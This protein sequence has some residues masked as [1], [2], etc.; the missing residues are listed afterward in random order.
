VSSE[1]CTKFMSLCQRRPDI[2]PQNARPAVS[3]HW[4]GFDDGNVRASSS[5]D[6][7]IDEP[8]VDLGGSSEKCNVGGSDSQVQRL[9]K[10]QGSVHTAPEP[11]T[12][13]QFK[14]TMQ[15]AVDK[16]ETETDV[17]PAPATGGLV[18]R[19][20]VKDRINMF[21][22]QK[23][24]QTPSSGN[25]NSAVANKAVPGKGE[26]RRVP[27]G[28]SMEKLVRRWSNVSDMSID[29]SNNDSSSLNEKKEDGTFIGTPTST[30]LEGNS[31][32]RADKDSSRLTDSVTSQPW[33]C[34]RDGMSMGSTSI[35]NCS[36]SVSNDVPSSYK[37]TKSCAEDDMVVNTSF[38]S[39]SSFGKE[40]VSGH[41]A[42]NFSTRNR[43]KTSPKP[44]EEAS[45]KHKDI[46][47]SSSPEEHVHMIDKEITAVVHEVPDSSEQ[48]GPNDTR[49][50]RLHTKD[51]HTE[52]DMMEKKAR[53]TRT[54]EKISGGVKPKSKALP[55]SR[56]NLRGSSGREEISSIETEGRDV[57]MQRN[58]VPIKADNM[59]RKVISGSDSDCSG[60][61]GSNL[62]RQSSNAE[63]ELNSQAKVRPA[64]G[65]QDRH[66]E[67][68]MKANELEKLYA[69]HKLTS[70]RRGKSTDAQ[71]D[72]TP[73][74]SEVKPVQ[75][76]PEKIYTKQ[77]VKESITTND[78]DA[79]ELLK[80]V[81]NQ[82]YSSIPQKF[83]ILSLE[84][85]RGKF[86]DQYMQKRDAKLKEDWKLQRQE[87]EAMLKA[88]HESLERSKAELQAKFA[89]SVDCSD[90]SY[91]SR[92]Q[93]TPPLQSTR[94]KKDQVLI[95][96]EISSLM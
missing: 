51:I 39:E 58:R 12:E 57:S 89:R 8:Q 36:L 60:R 17:S 65:N 25:S 30:D 63:Q 16:Q 93:K 82:G 79:N 59:G 3:S 87:K 32:L 22:S 28:A 21:E 80:M 15:Q 46:L 45:L 40:Q 6:M 84:E 5:S 78:F 68:Q 75:V 83:G 52:A 56:I 35:N 38:E 14:P 10:G 81:N 19:L 69:A 62:S 88:M 9:N 44:V 86:Y 24:E 1:A 74:V 77:I 33:S 85:S 61:Q 91:V 4:K 53:P 2:S 72:N 76:L 73:V 23:K 47:T 37:Q 70:S 20:S 42:P 64:K 96:F 71:V 67:L 41:A 48:I 26:H 43:L 54:F 34:Q 95:I 49:G 7:S 55:S 13:Q 29:L 50:P 94:K 31:K 18:R 27:S 66:G 92:S 11:V 90:S